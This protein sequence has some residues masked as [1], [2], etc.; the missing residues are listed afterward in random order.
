MDFFLPISSNNFGNCGQLA[1]SC[2]TGW[3]DCHLHM[4]RLRHLRMPTSLV[5]A[6]TSATSLVHAHTFLA[7]FVGITLRIWSFGFRVLGVSGFSGWGRDD[8]RFAWTHGMPQTRHFLFK[9]W[10]VLGGSGF[11]GWGRD[12]IRFAWTH[13]MPQTG[14]FLLRIGGFWVSGFGGFQV[15][16]VSGWGRDDIRFAWTHGMPQTGHFLLRFG[17]FWVSGFRGSGVFGVSGWGRDDIRFA[18]TTWHATDR[19]L[20]F[21]VWGVLGFGFWGFEVFGVSGWGRDDIRFAWTHGMPQTGHLVLG[22]PCFGG[23]GRSGFRVG[24]VV[25]TFVLHEHMGCWRHD[26]GF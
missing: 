22:F 8:I 21:K 10:G 1:L 7:V 23:F 15:F 20:S 26:T 9:V 16:G 2:T 18:W 13:G 4:R 6:R 17:G 11:S 19:T 25:L 5:H 3:P 12:D 24:V 14:H